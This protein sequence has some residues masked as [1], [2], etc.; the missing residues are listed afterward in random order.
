MKA[1]CWRGKHH[2]EVD[3]VPDPRIEASTDMIVRVKVSGIC[4]SDLHL[5]DGYVPTLKKGDILGHEAF[6]E[7][8]ET[9]PQVRRFHVGDRVAVPFNIACGVCYYCKR[10]L[11]SLCDNTNPNAEM[12]AKLYGYSPGGF[13][14]YSHMFGGY[15]GGQA[16]FLRVPY[17]DQIPVAIPPEIDGED[18]VLLTDNFPTGYMAAANCEIETGQTVAVFGAGAVGQFAAQSALLLGAGRVLLIDRYDYRLNRWPDDRITIINYESQD[19]FKTVDELTERH[20]ADAC[21]DAVGMEAQSGGPMDAYDTVKTKLK[22]ETDRP[23]ALRWAIHTCR[24]GGV[25]SVPGVYAG[26]VDKYPAG[27]FFN[28]GLTLR[29]GQTHVHRYLPPLL[30]LVREG[31]IKTSTVITHRI[32]LDQAPDYYKIFRNKENNCLKAIIKFP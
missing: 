32:T 29:T 22:L 17:A 23:I 6:G 14:G 8:V 13:F 20:G 3:A 4:G 11:Y 21:I 27:A 1:L 16:E 12:A 5:Y 30:D 10:G 24:K 9:G 25:V 2:V 31:K 7:V 26:F 19:V 15:A 18:A 28:K